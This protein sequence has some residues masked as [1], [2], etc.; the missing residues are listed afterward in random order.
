MISIKHCPECGHTLPDPP[1]FCN[2]CGSCLNKTCLKCEL[3]GFSKHCTQC[4]SEMVLPN[5]R[6]KYEPK[7]SKNNESSHKQP[8]APTDSSKTSK[9]QVNKLKLLIIFFKFQLLTTNLRA[10]HRMKL[11]SK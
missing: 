10:L 1:F 7:I 11:Q 9:N 8:S 4:G 6:S 5:V 3:I 2:W